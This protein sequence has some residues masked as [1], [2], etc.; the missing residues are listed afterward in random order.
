MLYNE[1]Q[2]GRNKERL[3]GIVVKIIKQIDSGQRIE[4]AIAH[5]K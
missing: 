3:I 1:T 4:R 5:T 2:T